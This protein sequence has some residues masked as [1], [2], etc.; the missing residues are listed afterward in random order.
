MIS[1]LSQRSEMRHVTDW[2]TVTLKEKEGGVLLRVR[3]LTKMLR[4][5]AA[6]GRGRA[7]RSRPRTTAARCACGRRGTRACAACRPR[8]ACAARSSR[9][10]ERGKRV[11]RGAA[12]G[13]GGREKKEG[14]EGG[15]EGRGHQSSV[16]ALDQTPQLAQPN[17]VRLG[18]AEKEGGR[19]GRASVR[20]FSQPVSQAVH[21]LQ[22]RPAQGS[23]QAVI[24]HSVIS[25]I[26][27]SLYISISR[28]GISKTTSHQSVVSVISV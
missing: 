21:L 25:V 4:P 6:A 27:V 26:S 17:P 10:V 8:P 22:L 24:S 1:S 18:K 13:K 16:G 7:A 15:E 14:K 23:Q 20:Q 19:E 2:A 11:K 12:G 28:M 3:M 5:A 9:T